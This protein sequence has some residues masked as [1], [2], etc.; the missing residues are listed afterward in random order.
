MTNTSKLNLPYILQSQSQKEVTHNDGLNLLDMLVQ[1]VVLE[2]GLDTPPVS[3]TLGGCYVIGNSPSGDWATHTGELTQAITGGWRFVAPF[4]GLLVYNL[5]D[6]KNYHYNGSSWAVETISEL[7]NMSLLGI[8]SSADSTNKLAV[9]SSAI[10][11]NNIGNGVQVK[12]NKATAGD[13]ASF[14]YQTNWSGRAEFGTTGDD[15]F[16]IKVS[17]DG[18]NWHESLI[19]DKDTGNASFQEKIEHHGII[20]GY[21]PPKGTIHKYGVPG[22]SLYSTGSGLSLTKD[23][24]YYSLIYVERPITVSG[25]FI[26][27]YTASTDA[28]AVI[29]AGLYKADFSADNNTQLG[30]GTLIADFGT[31]LSD[32]NAHLNYS[33]GTSVTLEKGWY[34]T[35]WGASGAGDKV[36][37]GR[38]MRPD[39]HRIYKYSSG[40]SSRPRTASYGYINSQSAQ[41]TGGLNAS[42][43]P[44][45]VGTSTNCWWIQAVF[46]E[47]MDL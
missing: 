21:N 26:A 39:A 43:A 28:G 10:L 35:C 5:S 33:L 14:L 1:A 40:T 12:L 13:S 6:D 9:A 42:P 23:R 22:M 24:L 38:A 7:Q 32:V 41:I 37:Y 34:Y 2:V 11:F 20:D 45:A 4:D 27:N 36:I 16:H 15:D 31:Q 8:N 17:P 18:S 19:I 30:I 46:L 44:V 3:P 47:Y 25:C 29:R